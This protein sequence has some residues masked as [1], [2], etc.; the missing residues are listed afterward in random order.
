M[1][2]QTLLRDEGMGKPGLPIP[3]L[4]GFALPNPSAGGGMGK[5]GLPIPLLEGFALPNPPTG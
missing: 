2:S 3:L 5:P 1:P 4:E